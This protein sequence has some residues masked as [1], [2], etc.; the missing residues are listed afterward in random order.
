MADKPREVPEEVTRLQEAIAA[1]AAIE[2]DAAC[3]AA[4]SD[5][6][7]EWPQYHAQ[8]RQLREDRVN[9]LRKEGKRT[10]R[11]IADI[12]GGVTPERAQQ[13]GRGLR[14]S[15]RPKP[16]NPRNNGPGERS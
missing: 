4:V 11:Q 3:T 16:L 10:W 12:I 8:L 1:F 5:V 7:R 15:K 13:I 6:L 2:D 14:G 9:S